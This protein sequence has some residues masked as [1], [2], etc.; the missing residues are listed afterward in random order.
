[1]EMCSTLS[2]A[3]FFAGLFHGLVG[4]IS[5]LMDIFWEVEVYDHCQQSWWYDGGFL[6]GVGVAVLIGMQGPIIAFVAF[7][8]LLICYIIGLVFDLVLIG[9][10]IGIGILITYL[11]Y[12]YLMAWYK[13]N[14]PPS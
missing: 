1:M 11:A 8:I 2:D 7:L 6:L 9:V 14:T 13:K 3:G 10:G 5:L 12:R 4:L